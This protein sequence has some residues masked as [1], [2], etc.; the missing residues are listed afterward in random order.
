[1]NDI[2]APAVE[3]LCERGGEADRSLRGLFP[4]VLPMSVSPLPL[5][6]KRPP[7]PAAVGMPQMSGTLGSLKQGRVQAWFHNLG[8][9]LVLSTSLGRSKMENSQTNGA[10]TYRLQKSGAVFTCTCIQLRLC[11]YIVAIVAV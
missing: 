4:L 1:M 10:R 8:I 3:T 6:L 7:K 2:S 11:S 9:G 5:A